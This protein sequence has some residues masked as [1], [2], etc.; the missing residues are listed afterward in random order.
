M[1]FLSK[2][3]NWNKI[4]LLFASLVF[5]FFFFLNLKNFLNYLALLPII[6]SLNTYFVFLTGNFLVGNL[7]LKIFFL[8]FILLFFNFLFLEIK[9]SFLDYIH[10]Y[11]VWLY[12]TSIIFILFGNIFIKL[13]YFI[14]FI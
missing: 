4:I 10:S 8:F 13:V 14:L 3:S 7:V 12:S 2:H 6:F 11:L 1:F 9:S 5:F